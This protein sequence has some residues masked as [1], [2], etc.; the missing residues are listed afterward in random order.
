MG[1]A[2]QM[3]PFLDL[4]KQNNRCGAALHAAYHRVTE[5]N[6]LILA[7]EVAAFEKAWAEYCHARF[8]V[9]V[10][11]GY[12]AIRFMLQCVGVTAGGTVAVASNAHI[13][14]WMAIESLGARI[15][16]IEPDYQTM[17][18]TVETIRATSGF[19][20]ATVFL[21][22]HLYGR[23]AYTRE[24]RRLADDMGAVLLF[25][26]CQAHGLMGEHLGHAAA[27][28]FYP[29]KNL[30]CLGDG[31]AIVTDSSSMNRM[32][33][34]LRNYG[35]ETKNIARFRNGANSRMDELQAAF[36]FAKLGYLDEWN[37]KRRQI[38]QAYNDA[39]KD[40][41][42]GLPT[43]EPGVWHLYVVKH[44]ARDEFR[45]RLASAG[46][47]TMIHYPIAPGMQSVY[48]NDANIP[49]TP[50]AFQLS[51]D[52]LSLPIDPL[53]TYEQMQRVIAAV[54]EHA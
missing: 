21:L 41:N 13:S 24:I 32:A 26:A 2:Q 8:C 36:L 3:I 6:Q 47:E 20:R 45:K 53:M 7:G 30:G 12:D 44:A 51:Q 38:A 48:M 49:H 28:S 50:I 39:F 31:G 40:L 25:D 29:T 11:N 35:G 19:Q 1:S 15:L 18:V 37:A 4:R 27:F 54:R 23:S 33:R 42:L 17:C 14:N 52:V 22:T 43:Q 46:V 16:P 5:S 34:S 10:G 9:L